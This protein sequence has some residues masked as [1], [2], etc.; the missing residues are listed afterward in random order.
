LVA[1]EPQIHFEIRKRLVL[2]IWFLRKN[3][4]KPSKIFPS[5]QKNSNPPD[6][7]IRTL[8]E[9]R[10]LLIERDHNWELCLNVRGRY[11]LTAMHYII[12]V[13][14]ISELWISR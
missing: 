9:D 2:E 3:I 13:S 11:E 6:Q 5:I 14:K 10:E 7:G 8:P 1:F 4:P 12:F